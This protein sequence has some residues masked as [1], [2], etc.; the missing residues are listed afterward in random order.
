MYPANCANTWR[1]IV[2]CRGQAMANLIYSY[3]YDYL[4]I[5]GL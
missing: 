1:I 4:S 5:V 3:A 2:F